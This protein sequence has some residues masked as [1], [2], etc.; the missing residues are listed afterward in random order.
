MPKLGQTA[1]IRIPRVPRIHR[2]HQRIPGHPG[3]RPI[4]LP[5]AQEIHIRRGEGEACDLDNTGTGNANDVHAHYRRVKVQYSG[6]R[7][8]AKALAS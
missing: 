1:H 2:P 5:E 8:A 6:F 7:P 3:A 4:G